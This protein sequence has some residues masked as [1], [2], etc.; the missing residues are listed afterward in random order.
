MFICSLMN[1][2]LTNLFFS[3]QLPEG[4]RFAWFRDWECEEYGAAEWDEA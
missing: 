2:H 3:Q 1:Y 4:L